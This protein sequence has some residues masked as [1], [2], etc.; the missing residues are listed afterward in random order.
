MATSGFGPFM[1]EKAMQSVALSIDDVS[2]VPMLVSEMPREL[3]VG[4]VDAVVVYPPNS[5][6]ARS[7]G[8]KTIF[9]SSKIPGQI[10]DVLAVSPSVWTRKRTLLKSFLVFKAHNYHFNNPSKANASIASARV[11]LQMN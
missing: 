7:F 10:L 3:S 1:L 6:K 8:A 5:E 4:N 11:L 2:I 9:D